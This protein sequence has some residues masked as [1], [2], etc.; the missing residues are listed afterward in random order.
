MPTFFLMAFVS[1]FEGERSLTKDC[2]ELAKFILSGISPAPRGTPEIEGTYEV[3]VFGVLKVKA[4]D[5]ATCI[6]EIIT[7]PNYK[8]RQS[9]E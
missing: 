7:I 2:Q 4:K 5:K 8:G 3:D 9:Q 6:E 1:G